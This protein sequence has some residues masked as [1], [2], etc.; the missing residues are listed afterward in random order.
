MI[1]IA[2]AGR[3]RPGWKKVSTFIEIPL[4]KVTILIARAGRER[5]GLKKVSIFIEIP[6]K[7]QR[8]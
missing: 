3:E 6:F 8:F 1:L 2:R 5:P 4:Q 7:K